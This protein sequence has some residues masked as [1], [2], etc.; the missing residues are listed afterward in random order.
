MC[1]EAAAFSH[2]AHRDE[3]I[4]SQRGDR[5][6]DRQARGVA[7]PVIERFCLAPDYTISRVIKGGWQLAGG[8]G[9]IE[10]ERALQDMLLYAQ[11]GITTFDC[12]DIYTGV[13]SLIGEFMRRHREAMREG[14]V[15]WIQVHTK[16][17]PDLD[18]LSTLTRKDVEVAVD[19][20]LRRLGPSASTWCSST[21][22]TM[23]YRATRKQLCIWRGFERRAKS[24][25]SP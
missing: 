5:S 6:A 19:R 17:V 8:H 25:T 14:Q 11:E 21:G 23:A 16:Y 2:R 9:S 10:R 24:G 7:L 18:T 13:E 20:S 15:P 3:S 4:P 1:A 22:G 12:A